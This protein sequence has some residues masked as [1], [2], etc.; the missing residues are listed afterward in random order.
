MSKTPIKTSKEIALMRES[1]AV[2]SSILCELLAFAKEGV[3]TIELNDLSEKRIEEHGVTASFKNFEGYPFSIVTCVNDEVVHGMP[4]EYTLKRGDLLTIDFGILKNGFHSDMAET[5]EI[6]TSR[7]S[8]FL[9]IGKKA[10]EVGIN[11]CK[12]GNFVGDI[13]YGIQST[14]EGSGYSVVRAFVGHGVGRELHEEPQVPGFGRPRMGALLREGTVLAVEV[15]YMKGKF[16]IDTKADGW[17]VVTRDGSLSAMFEHT[18]AITRDGP[19]ILTEFI[20]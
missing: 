18:V 6:G 15:M 2:A 19:Q 14:V 20:A 5:I 13:S 8:E 7:E 17:T 4:S 12:V 16:D 9:S 11:A 1:G 10:L 3:S